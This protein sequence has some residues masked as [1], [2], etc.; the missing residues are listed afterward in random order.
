VARAEC[1]GVSWPPRG[2]AV[3]AASVARPPPKPA[4]SSLPPPLPPPFPPL[5]VF[6]T[7]VISADFLCM[8]DR[9]SAETAACKERGRR[10]PTRQ[11][12]ERRAPQRDSVGH[13]LRS[14]G[15]ADSPRPLFADSTIDFGSGSAWRTMA[16]Y[17]PYSAM[18]ELRP[19]VFSVLRHFARRFW[20]QTWTNAR[21]ARCYGD[22]GRACTGKMRKT[23]R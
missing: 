6:C 13:R 20:N 14:Q 8:P 16:P 10:A 21:I 12:K 9:A 19:Q 3:F 11:Q 23:R 5:A 4:A 2:P 7:V 1:D 18:M 17:S 22:Y 15:A